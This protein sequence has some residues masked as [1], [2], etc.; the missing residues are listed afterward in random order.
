MGDLDTIQVALDLWDTTACCHRLMETKIMI[1]L[2][3]ERQIM[4]LGIHNTILTTHSA[5]TR[6]LKETQST[7]YHSGST[8]I[9]E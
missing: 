6:M 1:P 4:T 3:I 8:S 5:T 7:T 2:L 9:G